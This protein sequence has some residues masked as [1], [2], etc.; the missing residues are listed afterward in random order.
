MR[1]VT[2]S[3]QMNRFFLLALLLSESAHAHT[4]LG[5]SGFVAGFLHPILGLDHLLAMVSVGILSAQ[6]GGWAIFTVP[7]AFVSC[8]LFGGLLGILGIYWPLVELGITFSVILLGAALAAHGKIPRW[9]GLLLA[10]CFGI[11]HGHAHGTEMPQVADPFWFSLGFVG[12]TAAM[13]LLGVSIGLIGER[14]E[15]GD[16]LLRYLGAGISGVGLHILYEMVAPL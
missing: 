15:G 7:T 4:I 10:G 1:E 3:T 12:S 11:F 2:L 9:V 6:L 14:F 8:M 5:G 13:H 16:R